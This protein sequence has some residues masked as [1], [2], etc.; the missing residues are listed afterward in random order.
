MKARAFDQLIW[1]MPMPRLSMRNIFIAL[2]LTMAVLLPAP[3]RGQ[4]LTAK[5]D[6]V[7]NTLMSLD[8]A[9]GAGIVVVRDTQIV[10]MKGFG[11]ADA[12]AKKP[13]TAETGFY[14]ASTTKS[15]TGLAAALLDKKGTFKLD[16]PLHRYLPALKLKAPLNADSITIRSLLS[17]THGIGNGPVAIRLAYS[18]EYNGN[19]ELVKLL[20][21]HEAAKTGREFSYGNIGY[22]VAALAMDAVTRKSWKDVLQTEL[23]TPLNMKHTSAYVSKFARNDLAT[24]YSPTLDGWKARPYGKIDA[25]MQSAG[26]LITNLRDMGTWLEAHI[27]NGR[28]DGRQILPASA[29]AL[30]HS[31]FA[32]M[33]KKTQT[34]AQI[35]YSLGWNINLVGKDTVLVHGGG[36][37]GFAT[38]M[39]FIPSR[40]LGIAVFA[41]SDGLGAALTQI[42]TGLAYDALTNGAMKSP[43]PLDQVGA[44]ITQEKER[45]NA[46]LKRR[47]E[48]PQTLPFPLDAYTGVYENPAMGKLRITQLNGKLEANFGA[49]WSAIEVFDSAAN[50]LRIALFGGGE[51]VNVEMKDGKA[52][53][54]SFGGVEYKRVN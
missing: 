53:A 39:S 23:F 8:L 15:F 29:F 5:L 17:H 3:A 1:R 19:A 31:N 24:P 40:R 9:P 20:E 47:A 49:A 41:N 46:D 32:P 38:Y 11:Y 18:G 25:N 30:A 48:R 10:Y 54:L 37:P 2:T 27:N 28:I 21:Q 4:S 26:G 6:S 42:A 35:G 12:E 33:Q 22:N 13:F 44:I 36:F 34:G 14:I 52:V 50:K 43:F 51:V 7:M 45:M 16:A